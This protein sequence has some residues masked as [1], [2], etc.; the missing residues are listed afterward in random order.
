MK[1]IFSFIKKLVGII[2]IWLTVSIL[3]TPVIGVVQEFKG[4]PL[5]FWMDYILSAL[6]LAFLVIFFLIIVGLFMFF[7]YLLED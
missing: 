5:P 2:G 3:I 4:N 1:T 7:G 6:S